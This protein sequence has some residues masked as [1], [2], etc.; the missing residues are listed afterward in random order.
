METILGIAFFVVMVVYGLAN[1]QREKRA[2]MQGQ[3]RDPERPTAEEYEEQFRPGADVDP[4]SGAEILLRTERAAE[5]P[6]L[7]PGRQ[8]LETFLRG[9]REGDWQSVGG[10]PPPPRKEAPA[11]PRPAET[12]PSEP[13][14]AQA[15][16]SPPPMR[17][18][19]SAEAKGRP[20]SLRPRRSARPA[21]V[22]RSRTPVVFGR[23]LSSMRGTGKPR[24]KSFLFGDL[25][26][27]RK[28]LI[29]SEIIGP[30]KSERE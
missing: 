12:E 6:P 14:V 22:A 17:T 20:E 19:A 15:E 21:R 16:P 7:A 4:E 25:Q 24:M 30:P 26:G 11:A 2:L 10:P 9:A 29:F 1:R 23:S 18:A 3:H 28:A 13:D 8:L 5:E 27:V